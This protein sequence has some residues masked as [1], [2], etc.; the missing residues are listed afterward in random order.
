M[1]S[2]SG[3]AAAGLALLTGAA[4]AQAQPG[5]SPKVTHETTHAVIDAPTMVLP[6]PEVGAITL[7]LLAPESGLTTYAPPPDRYVPLAA[8]ALTPEYVEAVAPALIP[9]TAPTRIAAATLGAG[10]N[11]SERT[12]IALSDTTR[13]DTTRVASTRPIPARTLSRRV[14]ASAPGA[15]AAPLS[16][17][18]LA[19][20]PAQRQLVYRTLVQRSAARLADR[21]GDLVPRIDPSIESNYPLRAIYPADDSYG[22]IV[23]ASAARD[24]AHR[25]LGYQDSALDPYQAAYRRNGIPLVVGAR[26]P[27]SVALQA[28]PERLAARI[29]AAWPYGYAVIDNRVLLVDPSTGTIVAAITP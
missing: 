28:L 8:A 11:A 9:A 14:A 17:Q 24:Y 4:L 23:S 18:P 27:A 15:A 10:G 3:L 12:R 2:T 26:V 22:R 29:P 16:D 13:R 1:T 5:V 6:E 7:R 21:G 19:L 20:S 25:A